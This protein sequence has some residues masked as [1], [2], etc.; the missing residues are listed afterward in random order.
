MKQLGM[1]I[2]LLGL[3][4]GLVWTVSAQDARLNR[5]YCDYAFTVYN[6]VVDGQ[7]AV[8]IY[9]VDSVTGGG[10]QALVVTLDQTVDVPDTTTIAVNPQAAVA[11]GKQQGLFITAALTFD[12]DDAICA[13]Y[14]DSFTNPTRRYS[15]EQFPDGT[16][17]FNGL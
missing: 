5:G 13:F 12:D 1:L 3:C 10:G 4:V 9:R 16:I 7:E 8:V 11:F 2:G 15:G 17:F 14:M 6:D